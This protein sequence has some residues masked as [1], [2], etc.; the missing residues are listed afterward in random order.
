MRKLSF[1]K[2]AESK[3]S[4]SERWVGGGRGQC[5]S[6]VADE[7]SRLI[8]VYLLERT[9]TKEFTFT[10]FLNYGHFPFTLLSSAPTS[11]LKVKCGE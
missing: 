10:S 2:M 6:Q 7:L 5:K 9:S 1:T 3:S 8:L 4:G 11:F